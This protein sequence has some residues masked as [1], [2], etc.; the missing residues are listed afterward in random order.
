MLMQAEGG[1]MF[2][3][4]LNDKGGRLL[5]IAKGLPIPSIENA[6][7]WRKKKGA[8]ALSDEIKSA[9]ERDGFYWRRL[10]EH[11]KSA[12]PPSK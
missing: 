11:R 1:C 6:G 7:R 5:V 9:V 4:Y 10:A 8:V 12:S 2:D 3:V